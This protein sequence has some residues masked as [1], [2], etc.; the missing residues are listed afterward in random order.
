VQRE[1]L[2][3]VMKMEK[4]RVIGRDEEEVVVVEEGE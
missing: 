3:K 4:E 1:R 2:W